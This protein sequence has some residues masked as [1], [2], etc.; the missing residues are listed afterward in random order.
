MKSI[1][2]N[3]VIITITKT[4]KSRRL[5]MSTKMFGDEPSLFLMTCLNS[6]ISQIPL[7]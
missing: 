1:C 6:L 5:S 4:D 3:T 2:Y 7:S